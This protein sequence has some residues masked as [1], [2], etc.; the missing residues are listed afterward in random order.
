MGVKD[1]GVMLEATVCI[2][3][4][5]QGKRCKSIAK[6][7]RSLR[8]QKLAGM[9]GTAERANEFH[10][11]YKLDVEISERIGRLRAKIRM[12]ASTR[13]GVRNTTR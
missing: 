7:Q 3:R 10:D 8:H 4:W 9:T 2:R 11:I 13:R 1:A 12:I 5:K 6:M